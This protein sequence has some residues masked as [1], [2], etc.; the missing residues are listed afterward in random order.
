MDNI[1]KALDLVW[2]NLHSS[3]DTGEEDWEDV[4][5]AMAVIEET[6]GFNGYNEDGD[7]I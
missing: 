1:N 7:R 3:V 4:C 5:M 2:N 6:L